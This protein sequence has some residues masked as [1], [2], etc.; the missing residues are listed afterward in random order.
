[1]DIGE[2]YRGIQATLLYCGI[3][4]SFGESQN[5]G[6]LRLC[7][8]IIVWDILLGMLVVTVFTVSNP[9]LNTY[10]YT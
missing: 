4:Y 10:T 9:S 1:M 3:Y 8:G 6:Y 2:I 7:F 5:S